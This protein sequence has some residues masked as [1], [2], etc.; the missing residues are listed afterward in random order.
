M[1]MVYVPA[2]TFE[3][4]KDVDNGENVPVYREDP[5]HTVRL[6]G[7]WIDQKEVSV[8][9]FRQFAEATGYQTTAELQG[10]SYGWT[11]SGWEPIS[12]ANWINPKGPTS[13][14]SD[15]HPVV[16]V[17]WDDAM[18]YCEWVGGRLPTEAEWEFSA[19]G[20][21]GHLYPWGSKFEC[22]LGNFDDEVRIDK[23]VVAGGVGCDSYE[24]TAPVGSF[25]NGK[26]WVGALDLSGNVWEWVLDWYGEYPDEPQDNPT[27]PTHGEHRVLRGGS[28]KGR[29]VHVHSAIRNIN[30]PNVPN[31]DSGFRCV[32]HVDPEK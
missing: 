14:A 7:F 31:D 1:I 22:A 6:S 29:E 28:W 20:T 8:Y 4:G 19:R 18:A 5:V 24:V 15:S 10:W 30:R 11:Q 12:G 23:E 9:Q 3:M 26:S 17:S 21:E 2:G 27:G 32:T 13:R 25:P 16:H